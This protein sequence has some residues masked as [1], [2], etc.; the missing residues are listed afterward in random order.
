M[1]TGGKGD[2]QEVDENRYRKVRKIGRWGIRIG[3]GRRMRKIGRKD[4]E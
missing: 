1:R 2:G 4:W 3:R